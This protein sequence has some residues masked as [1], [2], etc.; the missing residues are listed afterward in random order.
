MLKRVETWCICNEIL[1][2]ADFSKHFCFQQDKFLYNL[3][4]RG[5]ILFRQCFHGC[6]A[7]PNQDTHDDAYETRV[8]EKKAER[9]ETN[10]VQTLQ[11]LSAGDWREEILG[12]CHTLRSTPGRCARPLEIWEMCFTRSDSA[13]ET[14]DLE[15]CES[16]EAAE[17]HDSPLC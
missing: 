8:A 15:G 17:P 16:L 2:I 13:R 10:Q 14:R 12:S 6:E 1:E 4:S 9:S 11:M 5:L 7:I 3:T